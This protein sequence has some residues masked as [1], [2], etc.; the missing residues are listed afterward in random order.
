MRNTPAILAAVSLTGAAHAQIAFDAFAPGG[1]FT[2]NWRYD[3]GGTQPTVP[4]R[5]GFGFVSQASGPL[6]DITAA[7][8]RA[9]GVT[10]ISVELYADST[11]SPGTPGAL[12]LSAA[13]AAP[14]GFPPPAPPTLT[15][16]S[17][18]QLL[19]GQSYFLIFAAL[20]SGAEMYW[21]LG[22]PDPTSAPHGPEAFRY[23]GGANWFTDSQAYGAFRLTV[24]SPAALTAL[25]IGGALGLRR[26]RA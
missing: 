5:L 15:L 1:T 24:P 6:T 10:S 9:T 18:P 4:N 13:F 25:A 23:A 2:P 26:R 12:L 8:Y 14:I 17:G 20:N 11:T 22:G 3:Y 19:Q 7:V 16:A 21:Y